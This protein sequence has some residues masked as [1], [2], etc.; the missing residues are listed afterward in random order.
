MLKFAVTV[1]AYELDWFVELQILS[2][3]HVFGKDVPILVSDD[4]S[5]RS[6]EIKEIAERYGV[7]HTVSQTHRSHF[8]GDCQAAVNALAF[9]ECEGADIAVKVSQRLLL[10]EPAVRDILEK[11]FADPDVWLCLPGRIAAGT[12]K[13]AES[14]FFS[15]LSCQSDVL[16]IRTGSIKPAELKE[17]YESRVR[18]RQSRHGSL[19]EAL[20]SD[21]ID[22]KF[23]HHYRLVLELTHP[24]PGRDPIFLRRCQVEAADFMKQAERLG[25]KRQ[26]AVY[27]QEWRALAGGA[28][29]PIPVWT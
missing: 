11:Y 22:T 9:A 12:I 13:R 6:V 17:T 15:N 14:R 4:I 7:H 24:Y 21:L 18:N 26:G 16:C 3:R 28:Y 25:L 10:C 29:R 23:N 8:G 27:L 20:W 5:K 2:L 19:I 1:G